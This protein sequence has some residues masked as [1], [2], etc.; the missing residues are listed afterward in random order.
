MGLVSPTEIQASRRPRRSVGF[1]LC[2]ANDTTSATPS[3]AVGA[4][5]GSGQSEGRPEWYCKVLFWLDYA[6]V[7]RQHLL[8]G[9]RLSLLLLR[10]GLECSSGLRR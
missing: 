7:V 9:G 3:V 8:G 10:P 6:V 1:G 5:D 2:D 4:S